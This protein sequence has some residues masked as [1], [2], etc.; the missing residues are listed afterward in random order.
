MAVARSDPADSAEAGNAHPTTTTH[1]LAG[2]EYDTDYNVR[3]RARYTDGENADSPWNGPWTETIA[4]VKL[5][6]P[7]TVNLM[8]AAVSPESQVFLFWSDPYD[9]S[10]TGYQIL[11]GPD[12]DNMVVI[13]DDTGSSSTSYTDTAPPAG[14]THSYA[15]KA[16]NPSGLSPL[17]GTLTATVPVEKK[18]DKEVLVVARHESNNDTLV[19]NLEQPDGSSL[20]E[21]G[22][23]EGSQKKAAVSFTTGD[24]VFGYHPTGVQLD[25]SDYH[26][27]TID[28]SIR[29]DNAGNPSDI[30]LSSLTK[31]TVIVDEDSITELTTFTTSD[32]TTLQ[33]NTKYWLQVTSIGFRAGFQQTESDQEDARSQAD[34]SIGNTQVERVGTAAWSMDTTSRVLKMRLLGHASDEIQQAVSETS[35]GD[36]AADNTTSGRLAV[37]GMVTGQH[38]AGILNVNPSIFDVDWFAFTA[39]VNTDYLFAANVGQR[40]ATLNVLR[41]FNDAGVEL[42]SSL[43]KGDVSTHAG[44][45][46]TSYQAVDRLNVLPFRTHTAGTYYVSI[47]SWH[48]NGPAVAY[49]LAMLGDDYSGDVYTTAAVEASAN[50]RSFEDFQ[51]YLMRTDASPES[52]N[53]D[54]VDWIRVTLKENATYEIVYDVGCQHRGIIEGIYNSVGQ[55][56]VFRLER[57]EVRAS[58]GITVHMC[59]NLVTEFTPSSDGDHYIAVSAKAPTV[60]T[61][62]GPDIDNNFIPISTNYP[63][64]GVQGTLSITVTS[65]PSTAETGDLPL[66]LQR[67]V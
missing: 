47:E 3:V 12:A 24:N 39:G 42:R 9:D 26:S 54:D 8:G 21:V 49:T 2:L 64:E 45:I 48:G 55:R 52:Q 29:E 35:G 36:L 59:T 28:V 37:D 1:T 25:L 53:T 11:R 60:V 16:R 58:N 46:E 38:H 4:Q 17:S 56:L 67:R 34:W 44:R 32:E 61:L 66:V 57:E 13:E 51:N 14:Q 30:V 10:I 50:G 63:F 22:L 31:P 33:P 65:P 62:R 7:M 27:T 15:V 5:P 23:Y 40:Q 18:K 41:I 20:V 19:S 6:L 43:I